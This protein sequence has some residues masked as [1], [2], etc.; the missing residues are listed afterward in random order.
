MLTASTISMSLQV[1]QATNFSLEALEAK[2]NSYETPASTEPSIGPI[3]Y[4]QWCSQRPVMIAGPTDLAGFML[5]PENFPAVRAPAVREKPMAK[6][7]D[8][9]TSLRR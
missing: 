3:Q 7:P 6:G 5:P 4:T 9:A 2:K 1:M 8:S